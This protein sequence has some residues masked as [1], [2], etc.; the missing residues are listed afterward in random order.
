MKS[1]KK[2]IV[3]A[4]AAI[5]LCLSLIAGATYAWFTDEA[6]TNVN[7]IQSGKLDVALEM[8]EGD[9][10]VSAEGKTLSFLKMNAEGE[11]VADENVLWEPGCTYKL[12]LLRIVNN[13][14]V[15]IKY[16][17]MF[18]GATGDTQLLNAL[19]FTTKVTRYRP[20]GSSYD[21]V[22]SNFGG[23]LFAGS[24]VSKPDENGEGF[25][26]AE[27]QITVK[28]KKE[29]GNEYQNLTIRNMAITVKA[30]QAPYEYDSIDN[31]YD[32]GLSFEG[33]LSF[34]NGSA[35][36]STGTKVTQPNGVALNVTGANTKVTV[37][38]GDFDGGEG[39]DNICVWAGNGASLKIN[40]GNFTVGGDASGAGN[41]TVYATG[42]ANVEIYG[43][44]F[45]S[46]CAYNGKY[47]VLNQNNTN[48]GTITVYGGTFVNYDP[49]TGDDNLGGN[50]VAEGYK[51]I[52]EAHGADTWYTVVAQPETKAALTNVFAK[53]GN[54]EVNND[55]VYGAVEDTV[56][57]SVTISKPTTL[58][59]YK[60][61]ISPND[62][63]NNN[64]N[65]CA[66]IVDADTTIN[67]TEEGGIDTGV[68]GGYGINVRKG[69]T[70]TINGGYYYGGG[71]AVQLQEGTLVINGGFF[72]CEP[73][74]NPV[75]GYKFLINCIDSAWKNGTAKVSITGG[76][77]V[78]F[79][80]MDSASE[81]PHGNFLAEGYKTVATTQANGDI[82]YTVVKA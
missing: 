76:T 64:T 58:K 1:F 39:G 40:K 19:T 14:N 29:A 5:A 30:T 36:I 60:K 71:T 37:N 43:G 9:G 78:N 41:S 69:A 77:F 73:Y 21:T 35:S 20:T 65:F 7:T 24:I 57:D 50:F 82:W 79:D 46:E 15:A 62:M 61:L 4:I 26:F 33:S 27:M 3:P 68:N 23:Q 16:T 25:A 45:K 34:E 2:I 51:V 72:A 31:K 52:S 80:P 22:Y 8:K 44:F 53:G 28:M 12:P 11:L 67:A 13:S 38:G 59:L 42:G 32:D 54:V 18:N 48:P 66:L 10:W 6:K 74:S 81:N 70:L 63:G 56:E 75:Y 49:S 55:I 17:V 47:Y